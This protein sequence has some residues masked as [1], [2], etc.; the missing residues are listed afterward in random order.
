MPKRRLEDC[1]H[2]ILPPGL[3][4]RVCGYYGHNHLT[5]KVMAPFWH[6]FNH[7]GAFQD[8]IWSKAKELFDT[9]FDEDTRSWGNWPP[10]PQECAA[11]GFILGK[12]SLLHFAVL[13][14]SATDNPNPPH[15]EQG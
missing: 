8:R 7:D 13:V 14:R 10:D 5:K 15:W 9:I 11:I 1:V 4:E 3:S 6:K 12:L 2:A